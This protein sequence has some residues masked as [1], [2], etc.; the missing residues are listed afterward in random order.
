MLDSQMPST[1]FEGLV[2]GVCV[3]DEQAGASQSQRDGPFA[4]LELQRLIEGAGGQVRPLHMESDVGSCTHV[5][6]RHAEQPGVRWAMESGA[7]PVSHFW[8]WECVEAQ[9]L[10]PTEDPL[11]RP[12]RE[13]ALPGSRHVQATLTGFQGAQRQHIIELL[14]VMGVRVQKSMLLSSI[15]HVVAKDT[16]DPASDK[17]VTARRYQD[18]RRIAIV[19]CLWVYECL[20]RGQVLDDGDFSRNAPPEA[21]PGRGALAIVSWRSRD[22]GEHLGTPSAGHLAAH[23]ADEGGMAG[24]VA[25]AEA[26]T[27]RLLAQLDAT[28]PPAHHVHSLASPAEEPAAGEKPRG[29]LPRVAADDGGPD[30]AA[31]DL[32]H[33]GREAGAGAAAK[34][35]KAEKAGRGP[36]RPRAKSGGPAPARRPAGHALGYGYIDGLQSHLWDARVTHVVAPELRRAVKTLSAFAAGVWVLRTSFLEASG[37]ACALLEP[38]EHELERC[39]SGLVADGAPRHWRLQA[40]ERGHGA[41]H[42]LRVALHG[43]FGRNAK[44]SREDVAAMLEA[45]GAAVVPVAQALASGADLAITRADCPRSDPKVRALLAAGIAVA[46][47]QYVVEWLAQ[48]WRVPSAHLLFGSAPG[49]ALAGAEAS[50]AGAPGL[51]EGSMSF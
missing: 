37:R 43:R 42:G 12:A 7:Q 10:L 28:S 48:P 8:V 34:S 3:A 5:V 19:N 46:A 36:G 39:M 23:P 20:R 17:L 50:R 14:R 45:G 13:A 11:Y 18:R 47:P 30:M 31:G 24:Q 49:A 1:L 29:V 16:H 35:S 33:A 26:M 27:G 15:T 32:K 2:L 51:D 4:V 41:F 25:A 44:P 40:A 6:A 21:D 38:E 9:Q 22:A